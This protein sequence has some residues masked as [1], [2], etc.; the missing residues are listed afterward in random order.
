MFKG[1]IYKPE[2][3]MEHNPHQTSFFLTPHSQQSSVTV[4]LS[5]LAPLA[6]SVLE[7]M[8]GNQ[9]TFLIPALSVTATTSPWTVMW[10]LP[11]A[12]T[13]LGTQREITASNASW[14]IMVIQPGASPVSPVS[15]PRQRGATLPHVSWTLTSLPL[16]TTVVWV[17]LVGAVNSVLMAS[18]AILW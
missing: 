16:V 6:S 9:G 15:V 5:T 8:L 18:L 10:T 1:S 12:P 2:Y 4:L 3:P 14:V 17:T 13:A 7:A 11:S